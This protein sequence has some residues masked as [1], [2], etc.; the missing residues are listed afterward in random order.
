MDAFRYDFYISYLLMSLFIMIGG[1]PEGNYTTMVSS[2]STHQSQIT[3]HRTHA[4][5]TG[6]SYTTANGEA[7]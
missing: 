7:K 3:A 4:Y 6:P 1:V 5:T 2:H